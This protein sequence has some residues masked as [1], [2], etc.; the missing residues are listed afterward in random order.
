M[1][2]KEWQGRASAHQH[3]N[4][5]LYRCF[6]HIAKLPEGNVL[7]TIDTSGRWN[8]ETRDNYNLKMVILGFI[9]FFQNENYWADGQQQELSTHSVTERP[10]KS[11]LC[12]KRTER[13]KN[14]QQTAVSE[15]PDQATKTIQST[16]GA[17]SRTGGLINLSLHFF[18]RETKFLMQV[19]QHLGGWGWGRL[20]P[21]YL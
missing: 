18:G 17:G 11:G 15:Q 19:S 3:E 16:W 5:M 2:G 4:F 14:T 9:E 20:R 1:R 21:S 10:D 8:A 7:L 6:P 12:S 13:L